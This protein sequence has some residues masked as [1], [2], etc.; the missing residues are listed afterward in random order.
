MGVRKPA[1]E[2]IA[3]FFLCRAGDSVVT[4]FGVVVVQELHR[5]S[6]PSLTY[7][8]FHF[9]ALRKFLPPPV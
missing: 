6:Q 4:V 5:K 8:L 9:E 2:L 7:S 1:I 3:G